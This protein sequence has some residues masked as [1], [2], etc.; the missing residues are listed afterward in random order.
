MR[1]GDPISATASSALSSPAPSSRPA[2]KSRWRGPF[3]P[4]AYVT[5]CGYSLLGLLACNP[6]NDAADAGPAPDVPVPA[7]AL[8]LQEDG[9][10]SLKLDGL[11]L[12]EVEAVV[13]LP[14][15]VEYR[16]SD[17]EDLLVEHEADIHRVSGTLGGIALR[18]ELET[19]E[20][21]IRAR[22]FAQGDG[23]IRGFVLR[24]RA[25]EGAKGVYQEGYSS[26]SPAHYVTLGQGDPGENT[27]TG[28]DGDHLFADPRISWWMGAL[29]YDRGTLVTGAL[30]ANV[31]KSRVL[32]FL[33]EEEDIAWRLV[34]GGTN[35]SIPAGDGVDSEELYFGIGY[36]PTSALDAYGVQVNE[37]QPMLEPP[38]IPTG[39][40]TWNT[41]FTDITPAD[42]LETATLLQDTLPGLGLNN[43]QIDDGWQ[44]AWGDWEE[45]EKFS[46]GIDKLADDLRA[47]GFKPGIWW[48]P[49]LADI[50]SETVTNHPEWLLLDELGEPVF[51]GSSTL[52]YRYYVLDISH[53]EV[54]AFVLDT[55]DRLLDAGFRYLKL[56]FLFGG[57]SEGVRFDIDMTGLMAFASLVDEM[58]ARAQEKEA[59]LLACG[60]PLLPSAGRFHA[61]RTGDDIAF[62]DL[63]YSFAM[64][65]NAF[66]NLASR[67]YV[68]RFLTSD[69]DT[70]LVREISEETQKLNI[71]ATLLSGRILNL[72]DNIRAL[73]A[74]RLGL[75]Q[76]IE[77]LYVP[78]TFLRDPEDPAPLFQPIDLFETPNVPIDNKFAHILAPDDYVVPSLWY[79]RLD[80][81][82]SLLAVI[83]W[84]EEDEWRQVALPADAKNA[85]SARG[86]WTQTALSVENGR[87]SME[88]PAR[89]V[90][91][92]LL[93]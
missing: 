75:L 73:D 1:N 5:L 63:S 80:E 39:W 89:G 29:H 47:R 38:F 30:S 31:F 8:E 27:L 56:D 67:F 46:E 35:E 14:G 44:V 19:K 40:N 72:G 64:N 93:R 88:I 13:L 23:R 21:H 71:S 81:E 42:V 69:P 37:V 62:A 16:L 2:A 58:S 28:I 32:S 77:D 83:N 49:F 15:E 61:L 65:K 60:S 92:L 10:F 86:L 82:K 70:V 53:P 57:A 34:V 4:A 26:W 78:A 25:T 18:L 59:Y 87:I 20:D 51:Y 22:L 41:Y 66:R 11:G 85:T 43:I 45:N 90:R 84:W 52:G 6:T 54:R 74:E 12:R 24:G 7:P 55:L 48:A 91:L 17:A 79:L 9:R 68:N 36:V 50:D 33:D 3:A 76:Q